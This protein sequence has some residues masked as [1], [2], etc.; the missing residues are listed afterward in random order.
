MKAGLGVELAFP[1]IEAGLPAALVR[2]DV[3]ARIASTL[4]EL[5]SIGGQA[6]R[7]IASGPWNLRSMG[8]RHRR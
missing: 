2:L 8:Q 4:V 1:D 6:R 5:Q 7:S 3:S